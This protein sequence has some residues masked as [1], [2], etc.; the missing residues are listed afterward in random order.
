MDAEFRFHLDSQISAYVSQGLSRGEAERRARCEFGAMELAKDECRDQRPVQWL[1]RFSRDIRYAFRS[2]RR[3]PG[4]TAASIVTLALG[5]GANAAIFSVVYAV[6]LKPLPYF[7]ADRIYSVG[8]VIPERRDQFASL[9]ARIQDFLEWR[10]ANTA[11]SAIAD[12]T[13]AEWNLTGDGEPERIGGARVSANFFSFLGVPMAHG[14]GFVPEEEQTGRD[15]VAVIS[16]ALWRRRYG[17][18]PALIGRSINLGGESD[19]VVGIAPASLLVPTGAALHPMLNFASRIDVWKPLAPASDELEGENW[20]QGLLVRLKPGESLE[21]GRQ[22]L[23]GMLNRSIRAEAPDLKTELITQLT[24]LREIYSGKIRLSLLLVLG[25]SALLLAIAC[26][27]IANLFLARV[28]SRAS[29]FA[30]RIALGAGRSR[31][32][33][34]MLTES[35]LI[36]I[37]GGALGAIIAGYGTTILATYGPADVRNLADTH[38]NLAVALFT[39]VTSL[40]TAAICGLFPAWQAYRQDAAISLQEGARMAFGGGM[41]SRAAGRVR[42]ILVGVEM[43]LGTALLASS[44]LLLHSFVKVMGAD[45]GYAVERV[46]AV[47]LIPSSQRYATGQR[48]AGLYREL[49][50]DIRA[51]PG[52]LAAGAISELPAASGTSGAS[53]TIFYATDTDFQSIVMKRP[54]ALIRSVTPGYFA[55]SRCALRAGRFL[56]EQEPIPAAVVSESLARRLWPAEALPGVVGRTFREGDVTGP[57][58]TVVGIV[59]DVRPAAVDRELPPQIYRP[60]PQRPSGRMTLVVRTSQEPGA[61]AAGVRAEIRKVDPDVPIPAMRTMREIVSASVAQRRFQMVLTFLFALVA[62]L[63]GAVGV[64]GVV[65]YSVACRTRDIGLRIALGA[66]QGDVMRWVFSDGMRPVLIGLAIGLGGAVTIAQALRSVLFGI[67]PADPVSLGAVV[68]V[69]LLTSSL[70]CYLPAH[71]AARLDPMVA[72]RHG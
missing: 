13:P 38:L 58:V 46:L 23:Q 6:L 72:L 1:D 49:T 8:V 12:L 4:F 67:T 5:I 21:R 52:V 29:E 71:R 15:R 53:Q 66:T 37:L 47:D 40:A 2:L 44:G 61:L 45:R 51:L 19:L 50:G 9:P 16:D 31:V 25:A 20:N 18:D 7:R 69:L 56:T 60:H 68:L 54:V 41:S 70:A 39:A 22:Q 42:Q 62:L 32:V 48:R 26:A 24:P 30:T 10:K 35:A 64:Y 28:A 59:E 43:A 63:L 55:A 14:R 34:Q 11:F 17:A 33:G 57:Q 36:A 3:S 27:N 65:S